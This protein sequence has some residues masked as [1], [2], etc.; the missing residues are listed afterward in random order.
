MPNMGNTHY[1]KLYTI[2]PG[3]GSDNPENQVEAIKSI[4]KQI[5]RSIGKDDG[6]RKK[7]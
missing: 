4:I 2:Y 3:K 7:V 5:G 6:A 1:K